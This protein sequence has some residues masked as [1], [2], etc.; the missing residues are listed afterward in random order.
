MSVKATIIFWRDDKVISE[1]GTYE[2]VQLPSA[3]DKITVHLFGGV[4]NPEGFEDIFE[5]LKVEHIPAT[6]DEEVPVARLL[7]EFVTGRS[8]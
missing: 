3:G 7:C 8:G 6:T 2:F 5:V 4:E 1:M